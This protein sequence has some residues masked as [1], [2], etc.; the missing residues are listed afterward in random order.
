MAQSSQN[1][2]TICFWWTPLHDV[3]KLIQTL[4]LGQW[5]ALSSN[6]PLQYPQKAQ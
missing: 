4:W 1:D 6:K 3:N 5:G 2:L